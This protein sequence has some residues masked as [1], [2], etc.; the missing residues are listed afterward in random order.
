MCDYAKPICMEYGEPN[1][2]SRIDKTSENTDIMT[3]FVEITGESSHEHNPRW[4]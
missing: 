3:N 2:Q 1:V 4:S